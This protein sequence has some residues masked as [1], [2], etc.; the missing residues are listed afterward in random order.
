MQL[1]EINAEVSKPRKRGRPARDIR[2][3]LEAAIAVF[4]REG[5]SA[6]TIEMIA[7][8]ACVSTATLYKRFTNKQGLFAAVLE[9]TTRQSL[10]IHTDNR[11]AKVHAFFPILSRLEAHATVCSD[12]QVRGVMRAW[13]GEV[14]NRA[15]I[16]EIFA[17][18]SGMELVIGLGNQLV[19][20]EEDGLIDLG[21]DPKKTCV[22][23]AQ[24]MLGIVERFTLMRGLILGDDVRPMISARQIAEKAVHAMMGIWGTPKGL[25]TFLAFIEPPLH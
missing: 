9:Q 12:P 25:A 8:Q 20:L 13:V 11:Q 19:K 15:E 18:K 4:A 6:A 21:D 23:A 10:G 24:I 22:I 3:V 14:R 2:P 17:R 16:G 7:T 1:E 5:F